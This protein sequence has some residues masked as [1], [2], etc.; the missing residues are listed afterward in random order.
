MNLVRILVQNGAMKDTDVPRL[1]EAVSASPSKP[2]HA[3]IV[4]RMD[5][6]TL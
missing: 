1:Q 3:L 5:V 6:S 4:I 2:L